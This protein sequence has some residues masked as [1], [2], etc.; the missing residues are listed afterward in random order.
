[1]IAFTKKIKNFENETKMYNVSN[2]KI[3][4]LIQQ[5]EKITRGNYFDCGFFL[6]FNLFLL[7]K[8]LDETPIEKKNL[9]NFDLN[10]KINFFRIEFVFQF[11]NRFELNLIDECNLFIEKYFN[12]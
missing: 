12:K 7:L 3:L 8:N 9:K 1:L 4:D 2:Y 10:E 11:I 5:N 6:Y